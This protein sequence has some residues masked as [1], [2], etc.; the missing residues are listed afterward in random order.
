MFLLRVNDGL[1][2]FIMIIAIPI[3]GDKDGSKEER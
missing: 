1:D 3:F 2:I